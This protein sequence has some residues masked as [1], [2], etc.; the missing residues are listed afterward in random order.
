MPKPNPKHVEKIVKEQMPGYSIKENEVADA[1]A[2]PADSTSPNL[3]ALREKYNIAEPAEG[4][5]TLDSA[6]T[7]LGVDTSGVDDAL[8]QLEPDGGGQTKA[9]VVS[10]QQEKIVGSQG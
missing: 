1:A 2:A 10:A 9:R 4:E 6:L 7:G 8:V 5:D 3:R